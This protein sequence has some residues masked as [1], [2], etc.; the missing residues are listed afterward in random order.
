MA[1]IQKKVIC[2]HP[3][4][5]KFLKKKSINPITGKRIRRG[6]SV[7]KRF[8]AAAKRLKSKKKRTK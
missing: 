5:K 7:Y 1:L 2:N 3:P 8:M 4:E 6:G